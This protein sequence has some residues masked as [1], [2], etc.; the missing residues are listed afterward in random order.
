MSATDLDE[1]RNDGRGY[2]DIGY[3]LLTESECC[4]I[5]LRDGVIRVKE[6]K[7]RISRLSSC[8]IFKLTEAKSNS[9]MLTSNFMSTFVYFSGKCLKFA[10]C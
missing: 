5:G 10:I 8:L 2:G 6:G 3:K 1:K 7:N 9:K 4:S